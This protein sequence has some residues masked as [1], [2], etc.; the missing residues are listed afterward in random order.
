MAREIY[1]T[2]AETDAAPVLGMGH[3]QNP[4]LLADIQQAQEIR[5]AQVL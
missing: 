1:L 2:V 5:D 3:Q 4:A